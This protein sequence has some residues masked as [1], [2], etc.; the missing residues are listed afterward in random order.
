MIGTKDQP[1]GLNSVLGRPFMSYIVK[2]DPAYDIMSFDAERDMQALASGLAAEVHQQN[3]DISTFIGRGGKLLLW[4]GFNDPGPSPL[5]T[6]EYFDR[7]REKVPCR[8]GQRAP[9]PRARRSALRRRRWTG[10]IRRADRDGA[11][12]RA[13]SA[14]GV[15]D[16]DESELA[17]LASALSVSADREIQGNG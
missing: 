2:H 16:R 5:S 6:I 14:A 4:H 11:L 12:G 3:P 1:R 8:E 15:D 10:S 7:V 9:L 13:G 17:P